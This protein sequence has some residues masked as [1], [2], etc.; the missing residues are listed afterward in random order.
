[1]NIFQRVFQ[2]KIQK[3]LFTLQAFWH[4]ADMVYTWGALLRRASKQFNV[5]SK[6]EGHTKVKRK[7]KTQEKIVAVRH[8][9]LKD[10][11]A[12]NSKT[13]TK[14]TFIWILSDAVCPLRKNFDA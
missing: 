10:L 9:L 2:S 14:I 3:V 11:T 7:K 13:W 6:A 4:G 5:A 8:S 1:M 12:A